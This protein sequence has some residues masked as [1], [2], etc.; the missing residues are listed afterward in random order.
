MNRDAESPQQQG[1]LAWL[2]QRVGRE[3]L[4]ARRAMTVIIV[5]TVFVTIVG[6][7]T[8]RLADKRDFSS[9]GEGMWWAVQTVTTVGYGDVVPNTTAGRLIGTLVML[10]GIAFISLIT[11]SVTAML[12]EQA[13]QRRR[14]ADPLAQRLDEISSRLDAIERRLDRR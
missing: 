12:V 5:T 7:L 6:G 10:T 14:E 13:R 1:A 3:P 9:L 11:A 8:I 4:N 2:A